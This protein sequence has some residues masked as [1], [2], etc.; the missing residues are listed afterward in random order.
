MRDYLNRVTI[1]LRNTRQRL[2][3]A[4]ARTSEPIAIVSM[5]CRF[6]GGVRTPEDLWDLLAEGRD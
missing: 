1:D 4:E 6:P 5:A 2:R 3:E